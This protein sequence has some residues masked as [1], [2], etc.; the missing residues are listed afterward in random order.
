MDDI[1]FSKS[2]LIALSEILP[3]NLTHVTRLGLISPI[4]EVR[5]GQRPRYSLEEVLKVAVME[6]ARA[7]H[8][9]YEASALFFDELKKTIERERQAQVKAGN[10]EFRT[11]WDQL[12]TGLTPRHVAWIMIKDDV[13]MRM[14]LWGRH[15]DDPQLDEFGIM[16]A[17]Q[18][19]PADA[20]EHFVILNIT[21]LI[22][23]ILEVGRRSP[24]SR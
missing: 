7:L 9:P 20:F 12:K 3:N 18:A 6:K 10:T 1:S 16:A 2:E 22:R 11:F 13:P 21:P 19:M 4:G 8:V 24:N 23:R 15:R 17:T 5:R 14:F